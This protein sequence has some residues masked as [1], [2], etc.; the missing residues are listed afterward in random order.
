MKGL[1]FSTKRYSQEQINHPIKTYL[2]FAVQHP[3]QLPVT[4]ILVVVGI[5]GAM[6]RGW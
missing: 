3:S 6:A 2:N 1:D 5:M 4:K